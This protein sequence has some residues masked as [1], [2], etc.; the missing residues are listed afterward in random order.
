[1]RTHMQRKRSYEGNGTYVILHSECTCK[2]LLQLLVCVEAH[3]LIHAM[4]KVM[5]CTWIAYFASYSLSSCLVFVSPSFHPIFSSS[6]CLDF[7]FFSFYSFILFIYFFIC[8][9]I[10]SF[11]HLFIYL[12]F[13]R[14]IYFSISLSISLSI[15]LF[16]YLFL[17]LFI[18]L[19][20]YLFTYLY[21]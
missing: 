15:Y 16:L 7:N 21:F 19:F 5:N 9:F 20:I 6:S 8:L 18:Y 17:Y 14:F 11:I 3:G 4:C 2:A 10:R 12:F 13:Y 1:M